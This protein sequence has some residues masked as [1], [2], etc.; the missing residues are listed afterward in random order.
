MM[1]CEFSLFKEISMTIKTGLTLAAS[2]VA[3]LAAG[4]SAQQVAQFEHDMAQVQQNASTRQRACAAAADSQW[5]LNAGAAA[6]SQE[7]SIGSGMYEYTVTA[8]NR[9]SICTV[10][11]TGMVRGI[12]NDGGGNG[13]QTGNYQGGSSNAGSDY[14][15]GCADA[16][17]G[18]YDRSGH[19]SRAYEDGWNAC[20]NTSSNQSGSIGNDYDRG[21]ADA[22]SGSYDRSGNASQAYENGWNACK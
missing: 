14:D 7:R 2:V 16:K 5:N 4:C 15:H 18:S 3:V 10:S 11:E 17:S 13:G 19:A 20:R 6:A 12:M 1:T 8:Q 21:C 22:K 9:S